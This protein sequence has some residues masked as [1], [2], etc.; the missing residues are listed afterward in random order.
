MNCNIALILIDDN[1]C[2]ILNLK[3]VNNFSKTISKQIDAGEMFDYNV[4]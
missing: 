2:G 4:N 3:Q 1:R